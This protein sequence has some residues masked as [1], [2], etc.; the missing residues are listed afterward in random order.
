MNRDSSVSDWLRSG[1]P[2][3]DSRQTHGFYFRHLF[4]SP[5]QLLRNTVSRVKAAGALKSTPNF[6][7]NTRIFFVH[8]Y[9]YAFT[10]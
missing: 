8:F 2:G 5:F 3:L 10:G 1:R 4:S 6:E 7:V 9:S